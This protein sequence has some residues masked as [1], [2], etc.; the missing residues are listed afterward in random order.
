M[1]QVDDDLSRRL[2]GRPGHSTGQ[3][4]AD[5]HAVEVGELGEF[6]HGH[7]AVAAFVG[8]DHHGFPPTAGLLFNSLQGQSLLLPDGAQ[9]TAE[10]TSVV[11]GHNS[12][13]PLGV[14]SAPAADHS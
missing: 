2:Q 11:A 10:C 7:R 5:R 6:R 1:L 3:Q 12:V 4:F 14:G 9:P 13:S 8:P